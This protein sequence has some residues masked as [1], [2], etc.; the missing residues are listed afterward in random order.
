VTDFIQNSHPGLLTALREK[1]ALTDE[2]KADLK[3]AIT[4]FK[5]TW[6][7]APP[8]KRGTTAPVATAAAGA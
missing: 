4:D 5:Q 6:D 1:K 7:S 8:A 3:T 2:I